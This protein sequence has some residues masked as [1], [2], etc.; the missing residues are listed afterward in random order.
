MTSGWARRLEKARQIRARAK[1]DDPD[2]D[3]Y[4]RYK[5]LRDSGLTL[6]QAALRLGKAPRDLRRLI[7]RVVQRDTV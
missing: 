7:I 5:A 2:G 6:E 3:V 1:R 4:R